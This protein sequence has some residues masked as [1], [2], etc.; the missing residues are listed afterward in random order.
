[1]AATQEELDHLAST[2]FTASVELTYEE[3]EE[4]LI[5]PKPTKKSDDDN[6]NQNTPTR[7]RLTSVSKSS[8][9]LVEKMDKHKHPCLCDCCDHNCCAKFISCSMVIG[10]LLYVIISIATP[11]AA[12]IAGTM[13]QDIFHTYSISD[14][15]S[16]C[17]DNYDE[18]IWNNWDLGTHGF[19]MSVFG[20]IDCLFL[21]CFGT[22]TVSYFLKT[23]MQTDKFCMSMIILIRVI[24]MLVWVTYGR[25][26]I[27]AY[28]TVNDICNEGTDFRNDLNDVFTWFIPIICISIACTGITVIITFV[29]CICFCQIDFRFF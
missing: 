15:N 25:L 4:D 1:M 18:F 13:I 17:N 5:S 12:I 24:F 7:L 11:I 14:I 3:T 28:I 2:K 10:S 8:R 23:S 26:M 29:L 19:H 9:Q 22:C 20:A 21:L 6:S 27:G 16:M